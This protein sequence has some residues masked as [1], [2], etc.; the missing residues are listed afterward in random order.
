M[1]ALL[2]L[3]L[4]YR[5]IENSKVDVFNGKDSEQYILQNWKGVKHTD[6][7]VSISNIKY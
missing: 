4:A 7:C 2:S 3:T 5:N 1:E 6:S